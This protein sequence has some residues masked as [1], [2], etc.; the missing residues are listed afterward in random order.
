MEPIDKNYLRSQ[1]LIKIYQ[2]NAIE[3]QS[4]FEDIMQNAYPDFQKIRPYGKKGDRGND[5]YRP[6]VGK[7]YQ[8]Y[9]P[10]KPSEKE[11]DAAK[12]LKEDFG[13]L[14]AAWDQISRIKTFYFVFNDKGLGVSIEIEGALAELKDANPSINFK[15]LV[16]KDLEDIFFKLRP[17][18]I[19]SLGFD[20]DS[21]K[22]LR[23]AREFLAKLEIDLD[24]DNGKFVS[25]ALENH[26]DI[27]SSLKDEN[28][29][30]EYEI[31]ECRAFQKIERVKEAKQGYESL[32]KRYPSDIRAFLY[33]AEIHLNNEDYEKNEEV[34]KEAERID[35]S[36]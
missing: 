19:L 27:I 24:R 25:R 8:V 15:T 10:M 1:F 11:A 2:K 32:C 5:G 21:T 23:I 17:D 26:K 31:L 29:L 28:L 14:K 20:V 13:A 12:K 9:A 18:Q 33:L 35:S 22:A 7:Y 30:I 34:L 36:H 4:F 16:A 6:D 3:Y